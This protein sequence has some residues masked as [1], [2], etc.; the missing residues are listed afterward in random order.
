[1]VGILIS[2]LDGGLHVKH[3]V[4]RGIWGLTKHFVLLERGKTTGNLD[5]V[6]LS[7]NLPDAN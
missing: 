7:Q 3:A 5:R 4:Q 1:M 2:T 6:G